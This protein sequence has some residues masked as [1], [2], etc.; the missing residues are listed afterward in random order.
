MYTGLFGGPNMLDL[1]N[2]ARCLAASG[3]TVMYTQMSG[4]RAA[5]WVMLLARWTV[6]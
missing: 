1:L 3:M 5:P 6:Y 4:F 2:D